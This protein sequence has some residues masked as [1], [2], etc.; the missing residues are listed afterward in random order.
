[1]LYPFWVCS[2]R[3]NQ[4]SLQVEVAAGG[5]AC[6]VAEQAGEGGGVVAEEA[7][8]SVAI[9][10]EQAAHLAGVV[11]VIDDEGLGGVAAA[12]TSATLFGVQAFVVG[13]AHAVAVREVAVA[14]VFGAVAGTG[15]GFVA[16]VGVAEPIGSHT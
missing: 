1:M 15:G 14:F 10:A 4:L 13:G 8:S 3:R 5:G 12:G 11:V 9:G 6:E 7:K 2:L 16:V